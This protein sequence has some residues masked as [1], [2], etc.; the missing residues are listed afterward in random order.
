MYKSTVEHRT[1]GKVAGEYVKISPWQ[2]MTVLQLQP[3]E[4]H[5]TARIQGSEWD[6]FAR[7]AYPTVGG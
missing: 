3:W 1:Y 7:K 4:W 6:S 2:E 5:G